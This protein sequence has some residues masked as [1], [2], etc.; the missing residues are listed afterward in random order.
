MGVFIFKIKTRVFVYKGLE[1]DARRLQF[2]R[3]SR[4]NLITIQT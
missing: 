3:Q 4:W 1:L 2:D